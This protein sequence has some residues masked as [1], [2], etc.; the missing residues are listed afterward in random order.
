M[1]NGFTFE[2]ETLIFAAL[3]S[4][5]LMKNG[6][7]GNLGEDVFVFGDDI[8]IPDDL[9]REAEAVLSY[10][11]FS[12]NREKSFSGSIGFRES[13]GGDFYEG[14]DV[15]PFYLKELRDDPWQL[16]PDYNGLH[17]NLERL[18][19]FTGRRDF[20]GLRGIFS[21]FPTEIRR[22]RGPKELGD[23]VLHSDDQSEWRIKWKEGIRYIRSVIRVNQYIS[24][25]HWK[26]EVVLACAVYGT[27]DGRLGVLP[28][29]APFSYKVKWVPFS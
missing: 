26:P 21:V 12:L 9:A 13:C 10:C 7:S 14:A 19:S 4:V 3:M 25:A 27:G 17:R 5:L 1:G 23:I 11:G 24:W 18:Q 6:R 29:D 15:R 2:L 8:L 22:C 28:R 20:S 16:L